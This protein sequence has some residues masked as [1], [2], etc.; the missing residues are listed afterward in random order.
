V[1]NGSPFEIENCSIDQLDIFAYGL[2]HVR[3]WIGEGDFESLRLTVMGV[4][5]SGKSTF[6]HTL[7]TAIRRLF[8]SK[9]AVA[10]CGPTGS[11]AFSAGGS[12]CHH[13]FSLPMDATLGEVGATKF[14]RIKQKLAK[15]VALI[16]E[17]RSMLSYGWNIIVNLERIMDKKMIK[18]KWEGIL[19]VILV[20]DDYQLP[21]IDFGVIHIFDSSSK[22]SFITVAGEP[23]LLEFAE[24][25]MKLDDSK[26]DSM[27]I[28]Q[29]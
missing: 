3:Q 27:G 10:V 6:I 9:D 15:V 8:H 23:I 19:I 12:T 5:G 11:A 21:S 16:V 17:E 29:D 20:G 26:K 28:K 7:V 2:D 4:A 18:S 22:K 25:V 1:H 24:N 14:K 13:L